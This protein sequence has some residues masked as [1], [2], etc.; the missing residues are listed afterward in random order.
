TSFALTSAI[1][2]ASIGRGVICADLGMIHPRSMLSS[3]MRWLDQRVD[4]LAREWGWS[5]Q[6]AVVA[7]SLGWDEYAELIDRASRGDSASAFATRASVQ[8][9]G[10][11]SSGWLRHS[12]AS[13]LYQLGMFL[14][15]AGEELD[16]A[17]AK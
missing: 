8:R 3:F 11:R 17:P 9:Q 5:G 6:N 10:V 14:Q 15:A 16:G 7:K 4:R 13:S 1:T 12:A 2:F